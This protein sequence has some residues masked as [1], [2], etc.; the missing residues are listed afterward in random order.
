MNERRPTAS[1]VIKNLEARLSQASELIGDARR[2]LSAA[3][4]IEEEARQ[5]AKGALGPTH[6]ASA[7]SLALMSFPLLSS[8]V[9][10]PL[11]VPAKSAPGNP[12]IS[13]EDKDASSK[14][15]WKSADQG[16]VTSLHGV[17]FPSARLAEAQVIVAEA[18][19]G[20]KNGNMT[21]LYANNRGK[22][23]WRRSLFKA[24][25]ESS[26]GA[27]ASA[28]HR[29]AL[30]LEAASGQQTT[31]AAPVTDAED[32]VIQPRRVHWETD[33]LDDLDPV[34]VGEQVAIA[35]EAEI[36][37]DASPAKEMPSAGAGE[38]SDVSHS[39][40]VQ[41]MRRPSYGNSN[42]MPD[43]L[44]EAIQSMRESGNDP[45]VPPSSRVR[46]R[47]SRPAFLRR[48]STG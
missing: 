43:G 34:K 3:A 21:N 6:G 46:S 20:V 35:P 12:A 19:G 1:E 18:I 31:P 33:P 37:A 48:G 45:T 39:V 14:A 41:T 16:D 7:L 28:D 9:E 24:A 4:Q 17:E 40:P 22:N 38:Q 23:A 27:V 2:L 30:P 44:T 8:M 15:P 26:T 42:P 13:S 11:Q 32:T 29:P 47:L 5:Y 36:P 10:D 25:M